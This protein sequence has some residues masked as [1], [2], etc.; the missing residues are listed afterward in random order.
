MSFIINPYSFG[1]GGGGATDPHWSNVVS[2]LHFNGADGSTTFNDEVTGTT[3][4]R[5][6]GAQI[7]TAQSKFGGSSGIFPAGV[8]SNYGCIDSN[9]DA[10]FAMGSGDFTF[11]GFLRISSSKGGARIIFDQRPLTQGAYPV[12]YVSSSGIYYY[13]AGSNR[14]SGS[15]VNLAGAWQHWAVCRSSGTTRLFLGGTKVGSDYTDSNNYLGNKFRYGNTSSAE[16]YDNLLGGWLD[17]C[18]ITKGVARYTA[19]FTPPTAAFP[20][21]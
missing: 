17:E 10:N 7:D 16:N 20:S 1:P 14:I 3:W 18:R 13:V 8:N 12:L 9:T 19:D 21:G 4:A 6:S 11:E 5:K 2:L 15:G